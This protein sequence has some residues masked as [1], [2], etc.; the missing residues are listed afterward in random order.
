MHS[1]DT[2]LSK[3]ERVDAPQGPLPVIV[4]GEADPA[5]AIAAAKANNAW[6]DDGRHPVRL[7]RVSWA[8]KQ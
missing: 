4:W 1:I 2:R 8:R 5:R 6:P 3:L 7:M